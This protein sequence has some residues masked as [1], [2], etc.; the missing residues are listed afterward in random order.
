M[1]RNEEVERIWFVVVVV[2]VVGGSD[3]LFCMGLGTEVKK[4]IA[5]Y[6]MTCATELT[7][8]Q[9]SYVS[10]LKK[11]TKFSLSSAYKIYL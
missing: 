9:Y 1:E 4:T 6:P 11:I 3:V 10:Y 8:C 5:V 7:L 2:I